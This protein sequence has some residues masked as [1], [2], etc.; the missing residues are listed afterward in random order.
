MQDQRV[1]RVAKKIR[2][3]TEEALA[4]ID[5]NE[6]KLLTGVSQNRV[7]MH[8]CWQRPTHTCEMDYER[9]AY[10]RQRP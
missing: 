4:V 6:E 7:A 5:T 9:S 1:V 10:G 2:A 3:H 8:E